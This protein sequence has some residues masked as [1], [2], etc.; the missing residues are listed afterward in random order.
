LWSGGFKWDAGRRR[1]WVGGK[2]CEGIQ[3]ESLENLNIRFWGPGDVLVGELEERS[4]IRGLVR[5]SG[6][7]EIENH[8]TLDLA[9]CGVQHRDERV[10]SKNMQDCALLLSGYRRYT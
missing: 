8:G 5:V 3:E 4:L 9:R 6:W 1:E 2:W 7:V 10:D